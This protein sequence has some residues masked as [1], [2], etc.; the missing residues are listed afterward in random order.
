MKAIQKSVQIAGIK[1]L[2][3]AKMLNECS[4]DFL[5]FP[6][7]L[8][9]NLPDLPINQTSEIIAKLKD[10]IQCVVITYLLKSEEIFYLCIYTGSRIVQ[11][12]G[13]IPWEELKRLKSLSPDLS[14]IKS[15]VIGKFEFY[16]LQRL[17]LDMEPYC[18]AFIAD[19]Y[20]PE[21][22]ACG[23]TG[24]LHDLTLSKK[25]NSLTSKPL[26]L[27]G[28]LTPKNVQNSVLRVEPA[29]VDV[30]TGVEDENGNKSRFKVLK[31]VQ[32]AKKR[33]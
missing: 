27:A 28:G 22:G 7:Y 16:H 1:S 3:E 10:R 5:G 31:F 4:A 30:H 2:R 26:I 15:L 6:L 20:N 14:I 17:L 29:G 8:E 13:D 12:H 24:A 19:T 18:E 9:K 21:T 25:L 11:L 33:I 32:N 23:A